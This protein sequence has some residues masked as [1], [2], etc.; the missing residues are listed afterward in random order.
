MTKYSKATLMFGYVILP[1][2][3]VIFLTDRIISSILFWIPL[4]SFKEYFDTVNFFVG[5][6]IRILF[7][8]LGFIIY[9]L[10]L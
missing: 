4:R 7:F 8:L 3:F 9:N 2:M 5:S 1:V 10:V 6:L